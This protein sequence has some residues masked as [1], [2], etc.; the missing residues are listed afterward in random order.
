[1]KESCYLCKKNLTRKPLSFLL[2]SSGL[3][4]DAYPRVELRVVSPKTFLPGCKVLVPGI[5]FLIQIKNLQL[6]VNLQ[7]RI[8]SYDPSILAVFTTMYVQHWGCS[9]LDCF[10]ETLVG[11]G[12]KVFLIRQ[13]TN[14]VKFR[15]NLDTGSL[16]PGHTRAARFFLNQHYQTGKNFAKWPTSYIL[17]PSK[18]YPILDFWF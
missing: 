7:T 1:M 15:S 13:G 8:Q 12:K 11:I 16:M 18:I 2:Q 4:T 6:E 5:E 10:L 3:I 14:F 9:W 17:R